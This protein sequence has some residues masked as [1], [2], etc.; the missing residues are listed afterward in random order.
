MAR[1]LVVE[2]EPTVRRLMRRIIAAQGHE[3]IEAADMPQALG[4]LEQRPD[5]IFVDVDLPAG[6]GA[7]FVL[8][9]RQHLTLAETPAMF[10]T[11]FQDRVYP[12]LAAGLADRRVVEKP[13]R[14][15][16][17]VS[18]L[19]RMLNTGMHRRNRRVRLRPGKVKV[20]LDSNAEATLADISVGGA[21]IHTPASH[22]SGEVVSVAMDFE[23]SQ[24]T[25]D[26]TIKHVKAGSL[27]CV[28]A[29][30]DSSKRG[31]LGRL[32]EELIRGGAVLPERIRAR[33]TRSGVVVF[34]VEHGEVRESE[35][36]DISSSGAFVVDETVPAV[37]KMIS[38]HI[39][40]SFGG[41]LEEGAPRVTGSDAKVVRND[42]HGFACVYVDPNAEFRRAVFDLMHSSTLR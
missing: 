15:A 8:R 31:E 32:I 39:P 27:G 9:L 23:G 18:A 20:T 37:D 38:L 41:T 12:I 6:S 40:Y 29:D 42:T 14:C 13:F 33:R 11:A 17:I 26:A 35:L 36:R 22:Q 1:V 4:R 5:A 25:L 34:V 16:D 2:D 3:V 28:F 30:L 24:L 7:Q 21:L 10:V 19:N